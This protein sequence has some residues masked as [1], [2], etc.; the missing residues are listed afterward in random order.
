MIEAKVAGEPNTST[1]EKPQTITM[2]MII[3]DLDNGIDREGIR[4]KYNLAKWEVSE[5]FKHPSLKGK[6]AK[7]KKALSFNFVDDTQTDSNQTSIPMPEEDYNEDD[8]NDEETRKAEREMEHSAE[9]NTL[10]I[11]QD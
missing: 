4:T 11:S 9:L 6:K 7:K 3:E 5:M 8:H 10:G 1:N 2:S